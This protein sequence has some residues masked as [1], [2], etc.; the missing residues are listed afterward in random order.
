MCTGATWVPFRC[1]ERL[2]QDGGKPNGATANS[3]FV[4]QRAGARIFLGVLRMVELR[5]E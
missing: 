2:P 1:T 3:S 5:F 4:R